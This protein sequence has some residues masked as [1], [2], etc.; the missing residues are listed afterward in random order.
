[1]MKIVIQFLFIGIITCNYLQA[2]DKDSTST[3]SEKVYAE[4]TELIIKVSVPTYSSF[5]LNKGDR[6]GKTNGVL[7]FGVNGEYY[8]KDNISIDVRFGFA[9]DEPFMFADQPD[10]DEKYNSTAVSF[11]AVHFGREWRYFHTSLGL[12]INQSNYFETNPVVLPD[13][14]IQNRNSLVQNHLSAGFSA[15]FHPIEYFSLDITYF[16]SLIGWKE[17]Q[18]ELHYTHLFMIELNLRF[19]TKK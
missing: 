3:S 1:M 14:V 7:G 15:S 17:K 6:Y 4:K 5:Y 16:P 10:I 18:L 2:Q 9:V 19:K 13:T 12:Q 11:L 8:I